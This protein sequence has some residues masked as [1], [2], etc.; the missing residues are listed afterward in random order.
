MILEYKRKRADG[1]TQKHCGGCIY[2]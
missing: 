1:G 2:N